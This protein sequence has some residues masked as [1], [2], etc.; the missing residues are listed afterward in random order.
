MPRPDDDHP[1]EHLHKPFPNP[2]HPTLRWMDGWTDGCFLV[3][4]P[5][6][7]CR[8]DYLHDYPHKYQIL[9]P[10]LETGMWPALV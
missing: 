9:K 3:D 7:V 4:F 8:D 10:Y 2:K 6:D 1:H 5:W